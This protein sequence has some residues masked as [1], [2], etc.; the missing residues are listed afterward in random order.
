MGV[1]CRW[2]RGP[3]RQPLLDL[4]VLVRRVVVQYQ[5]DVQLRRHL[6]VDQAQERQELLVAVPLP[7]LAD[8][9]AGGDVQGG[10]QCRRAVPDVV[11]GVAF[12]V[13]QAHRQRRLGAIERLNLRLLVHTQDHRVVRRVEVQ[14]DNVA[15][16]LDEERVGGQLEGLRQVR[17]DPE[18]SEPTLHRALGNALGTRQ[19]AR[20]PV[21]GGVGRLPQRTADDRCYL[22]V[23][24]G[25]GPTGSEFVVQAL[26]AG[27]SEAPSPLAD[28]LRCDADAP[29]DGSVGQAF[30]AGEN[31]AG[32]LHQGVG[33]GGRVSNSAELILLLVGEREWCQ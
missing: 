8:H 23:V 31:H 12:D 1:K 6:P 26:D 15:H 18:Q 7:A 9:P 22:V 17:L 2:K 14:P 11:V 5:V 16:F 24:I 21:R 33:Q 3:R 25:P 29:G 27:R 20:A 10:K 4:G 30:G 19:R 13:A 32:P 28:G